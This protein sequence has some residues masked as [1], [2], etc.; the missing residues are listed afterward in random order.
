MKLI[1]KLFFP[2]LFAL[3]GLFL[4]FFG[5]THEQNTY[6]LLASLIL[7]FVGAAMYFMVF[8]SLTKQI[9][10]L[11]LAVFGVFSLL[12]T[13]WS[14]SSIKEPLD[15]ETIKNTRYPYVIQKLK[16]I[17]EAQLLHKKVKGDYASTLDSLVLFVNTGKVPVVKAIGDRPDTL[18]E[19][20]ALKKGLMKRDTVYVTASEALFSDEYK[21]TRFSAMPFVVDSMPYIP[22][23]KG[24]RF[25]MEKG[26]V[27]KNNLKVKTLLVTVP[28]EVLFFD[29][30]KPELYRDLKDLS[31]G[32]SSEPILN[33]NWE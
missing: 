21:K 28:K 11:L 17:R 4:L 16:D 19:E 24:E 23:A 22:F 25:E 29:I 12:L 30:E 33:G 32:S 13:S 6:F 18:T 5:T 26:E 20:E 7:F 9:Q 31:F 3:S 8:G 1:S 14:I 10:I 2:T 15:F 27:E